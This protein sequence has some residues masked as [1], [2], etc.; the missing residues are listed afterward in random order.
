MTSRRLTELGIK[1]PLAYLQVSEG[2]RLGTSAKMLVWSVLFILLY[3]CP[4][5]CVCM[6][7]ILTGQISLNCTANCLPSKKV[8]DAT[9]RVSAHFTGRYTCQAIIVCDNGYENRTIEVR[10]SNVYYF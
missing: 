3:N 2:Q 1:C 8:V 10:Y 9:W 4:L 7:Y 5:E 6:Q